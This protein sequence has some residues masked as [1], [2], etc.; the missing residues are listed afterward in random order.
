M[1]LRREDLLKLQI[2]PSRA[3]RSLLGSLIAVSIPFNRGGGGGRGI[4]DGASGGGGGGD[5]TFEPD[6]LYLSLNLY[7]SY[8]LYTIK[9]LFLII[10]FK[11]AN[12]DLLHSPLIDG[13]VEVPIEVAVLLLTLSDLSPL[14]TLSLFLVSN[15]C[16]LAN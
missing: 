16:S 7:S 3:D 10:L 14:L 2:A 1:V 4:P 9:Y 6:K 15:C 12:I 13:G 11:H 5:G 8:V